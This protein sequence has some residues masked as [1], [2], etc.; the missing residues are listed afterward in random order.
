MKG[1]GGFFELEIPHGGSL[2][3]PRATAL[4]TGRACLMVILDQLRPKRVYVPFYT[5]DATLEPFS[6]LGIETL[7]YGLDESL[8]PDHLPVLERGEYLLWT[9][10]FGICGAHTE[11]LKQEFGVCLLIDDTHN[12]F[13][14]G[15][16]GHWSFTSARKYFGVPDGAFLYSPH[17]VELAATRFSGVSITHNLLRRLGR[18]EEGYTAFQAYERSLDCTVHR[19]STVSEGL[20]RG[21]DFDR[22]ARTR[23]VNFAFL[24][25]A[26]G[27]HNLLPVSLT[28]QVPFCYPYLPP[29][30]V[31]RAELH[32]RGFF[33]P[34]FWPDIER[35]TQVGYS[36]ERN[37]SAHLLPLP[38][39]HRYAP[40]DLAGLVEHLMEG[41]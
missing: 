21:V 27:R 38:I 12:F 8:F 36:L 3:H 17:A 14:E 31:D 40:A 2:P 25:K 18:L 16:A 11:R 22:V 7:S 29:R 9:D 5:C 24:H 26:L 34:R 28:E 30:P 41:T 20:L 35:R 37:F 13:C 4:S 1:I 6:Q 23:R 39:D 15:H 33:I 32:T 19:I 10:Y